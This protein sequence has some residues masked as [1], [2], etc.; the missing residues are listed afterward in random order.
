MALAECPHLE[1]EGTFTHFASAEDFV[2]GADGDAGKNCFVRVLTGCGR[3]GV[4]PGIVHLANSGA[5][6]RARTET[7]AD[8]VRPGAILYGYHQ[9]FDPPKK[10]ERGD[11]ADAARGRVF[12]CARANYFAA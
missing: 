11:G 4:E 6:L 5:I 12:R 1:L 3:L 10:A 7:W 2:G 9:R 8:M